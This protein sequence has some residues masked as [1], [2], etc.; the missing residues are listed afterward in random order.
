MEPTTD[1][2][3]IVGPL[4][5][6]ED[7][8]PTMTSQASL[9]LARDL[10]GK[11]VVLKRTTARSREQLDSAQNEVSLLRKI[12]HPNVVAFCGV[13]I[14]PLQPFGAEI[15]LL[16]ELCPGGNL[17]DLQR[18]R[19]QAGRPLTEQEI[20]RLFVQCCRGVECL[21]R[22]DPPVAHRDVKLENLLLGGEDGRTVKLCDF[23]SATTRRTLVTTKEE[24]VRLEEEVLR[25]TTPSYR[26]PE[27]VDLYSR[28]LV[29]EQV[30][31]WAL[32]C[33]LYALAFGKHAFGDEGSVLAILSGK[34]VFPTEPYYSQEFKLLIYWLLESDPNIRPRV[35]DVVDELDLLLG[36]RVKIPAEKRGSGN[37][38]RSVSKLQVMSDATKANSALPYANN[39]KK[40]QP[41]ILGLSGPQPSTTARGA[42]YIAAPHNSASNVPSGATTAPI[43]NIFELPLGSPTNPSA[44]S[45]TARGVR[46]GAMESRRS[47]QSQRAAAPL[48]GV[49]ASTQ[50]SAQQQMVPNQQA[51]KPALPPTTPIMR[52]SQPPN[53]NKAS[54]NPF[55]DLLPS[56]APTFFSTPGMRS[57]SVAGFPD[58]FPIDVPIVPAQIP[59][60]SQTNFSSLSLFNFG[61]PD[62]A[63]R[64]GNG[65]VVHASSTF[66]L[67]SLPPSQAPIFYSEPP[68]QWRNT[69]GM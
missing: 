60:Q 5:V 65:E 28:K 66:N 48:L 58:D 13:W 56:E 20:V 3:K 9:F 30:D 27:L 19:E 67:G 51:A 18:R 40:K 55:D 4:L 32:G 38:S 12:R 16:M 23:G 59:G 26:A 54:N 39:T 46:S 17:L 53:A 7:G 35:G 37:G 33:A 34:F 44:S 11:E 24:R 52:P 22:F 68:P 14:R 25:L 49:N 6:A 1:L 15:N 57:N 62:L 63:H 41:D 64:D 61:Q 10:T 21:H 50:T 69:K 8:G 43:R 45:G 31:V 42:A 29:S 36:N 47:Q 2:A